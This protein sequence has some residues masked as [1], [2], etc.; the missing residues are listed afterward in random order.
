MNI[1]EL[2]KPKQK[3][4]ASEINAELF[5]KAQKLCKK[6]K[7]KLKQAIEFGLQKFI[8]EAQK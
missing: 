1:K 3:K 2:K 4:F 5:E 6:N 7:I 8:E